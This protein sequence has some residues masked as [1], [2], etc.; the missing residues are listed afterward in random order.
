ML[1][2][3]TLVLI[4]FALP[5]LFPAALVRW[6]RTLLDGL[7]R[8][9][10][11]GEREMVYLERLAAAQRDWATRLTTL[12][13]RL[14]NAR[15]G[16]ARDLL[17]IQALA[18]GERF[19][20]EGEGQAR[21]AVLEQT[22]QLCRSLRAALVARQRSKKRGQAQGLTPVSVSAQR[23]ALAAQPRVPAAPA[24]SAVLFRAD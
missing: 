22:E 7:E 8:R 11:R 14:S 15:E 5:L 9:R 13:R 17:L 19:V 24:R 12:R 1:R 18:A 20:Q 21:P 6:F 10:R 23:R 16:D 2:L 4:M 3:P